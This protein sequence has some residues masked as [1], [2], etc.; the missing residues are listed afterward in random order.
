MYNKKQKSKK[1]GKYE[2]K[3]RGR[4]KKRQDGS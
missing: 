3:E 1:G 2:S 4:K